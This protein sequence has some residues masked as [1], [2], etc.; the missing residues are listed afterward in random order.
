MDLAHESAIQTSHIY[1]LT[2]INHASVRLRP[3]TMTSDTSKQ[4]NRVT[5]NSESPINQSASK[6]SNH[7]NAA[8]TWYSFAHLYQHTKTVPSASNSPHR[9]HSANVSLYKAWN[10]PKAENHH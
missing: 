2:F 9:N 4:N 6:K 8:V 7:A 3:S 10:I 1:Y 5:I